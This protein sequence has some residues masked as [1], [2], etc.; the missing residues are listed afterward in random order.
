MRWAV[1]YAFGRLF[2][3]ALVA[4]LFVC[5]FHTA[6]GG[7]DAYVSQVNRWLGLDALMRALSHS[8]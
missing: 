4:L 2:I 7:A 8:W 6:D 3:L 5:V 1:A